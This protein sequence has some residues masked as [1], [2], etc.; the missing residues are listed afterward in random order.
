MSKLP[1][2]TI[3]YEDAS[4]VVI[5]KPAGI[6]A[7]PDGRVG[8]PYITDWFLSE[9]PK[10]K[11]VGEHT[12]T[13]EGDEIKRPGIVHRLDRDT[14]GVMILTK[15]QK[16]HEYFKEQFQERT[17]NKKYLAFVWGEM[18][19][20]F[21]N[22]DRPIGRDGSDFRKWSAQRGARGELR[23]AQTYWTR[24]ANWKAEDANTDW[25]RAGISLIQAEP[26]TGRTHQIRVHMNS[27]H[28][29]VIGDIL[30]APKREMYLG[31]ERLALH[32]QSIEFTDMKGKKQIVKAP[33]P[34][35]FKNALK[36]IGKSDIV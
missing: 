36:I 33:L 17:I 16:A 32:A 11:D 18:K 35:D 13:P 3:L 23:E 27:I 28:H 7:H 29:P 34:K 21:G 30:Y 22:I 1:K 20:E 24:L 5:N 2:I 25:E 14:S 15:T 9:Y 12:R 31:F 26:K 19:E 10:S 6:M 8:G 4:C